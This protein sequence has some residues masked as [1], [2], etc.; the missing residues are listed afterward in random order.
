MSAMSAITAVSA[1]QF[2]A[3]AWA[4][5]YPS[6]TVRIITTPVASG[7]DVIAREMA[8]G[9]SG[10]LGASIIVENRPALSAIEAVAK[11]PPDGY[12]LLVNGSVVWI[13]PLLHKDTPWDPVRDFAP[14]TLAARS[15]NVL[16]V[17]PSVPAKSV[18]ELVALAK[19][20][21]GALS[22]VSAGPGSTSH[23]AAELFKNMAGGLNILGIAYKGAGPGMIDLMEG[24]VQIGFL[25]AASVVGQVKAGK[26]R[27]LAV[28]SREPSAIA[29]GLPTMS[30]SGLPGYES[31]LML[32]AFAPAK[33]SAAII[34]RLNREMVKVLN[35]PAAKKKLFAAGA[36]VV[37]STPEELLA[38]GKADMARWGKVITEAGIKLQ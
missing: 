13:Q 35:G 16:V 20:K 26:L 22:Y 23:L 9:M 30:D 17:T 5:D 18:A 28:T 3:T 11:S 37:G 10:P 33:T 27:A 19:A 36:E 2:G 7:G 38:A 32:G 14:I 21:P 1:L 8:A 29:E 15:P 31:V 12:T 25:V 6:R 4:Q 24:R 34:T